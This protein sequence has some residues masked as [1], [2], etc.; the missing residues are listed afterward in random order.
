ME[1]NGDWSGQ[2]LAEFLAAV[3]S[4]P[5]EAAAIAGGVERMAEAVEA[6]IGALVRSGRVVSSVGFPRGRVPEG[7][8]CRLTTGELHALDVPGV[9]SCR[10]VSI[11]LEEERSSFLVLARSGDDFSHQE[12]SLIGA[13]ARVLSLTLRMLR[14]LEAE[15]ASRE[16]SER[17]AEENAG[18]LASLQER[19]NLL[20]RLF[21]IQQSISHRAPIADVLDAITDGA[22]QLLG[23]DVVGLRLLDPEDP[24]MLVMVSSRGMEDELA[25]SLDRSAIDEGVGGLVVKE[26][27]LVV[28]HDYA[29]LGHPL[30]PLVTDGLKTAMG[31]PVFQDGNPIGSLVVASHDADRRY[32]STEQE[33]L[34]AFAEHASLALN[35]ASAVEAMRKAFADAV[36]QAHHDTLTG[37]PNRAL[38]LERLGQALARRHRPPR[39]V[40]V[41]F[42]D[43][44]RFKVVNDTLGHSVGDEVLIRIGERLQAA[45]RPDDTVGRLAGDEFVVVCDQVDGEELLQIAE[46]AARTIEAPLSLYGRDAVITASIGVAHVS[47]NAHP[48]EVL[49]DADVAMY[50]AKQRGRARIEA[51]DSA[52]RERL[53][54]RLEIEHALRRAL[55][56]DEL[57]LH[58]QPIIRCGDGRLLGVEALVRWQH[59]DRGLVQ[60][61]GFISVAEETDLILPIGRWV[62]AEA[63]AQLGRWQA[64]NPDLHD[65]QVAVNLS[66]RQFTDPGIVSNVAEALERAG[67]SPSSLALEITESVLMEEVEATAETLRALKQLGVS[68]SIDDFGTGYS[69][70]SYL[71]RFPVDSLKI[72]R[73]FVDG[74]AVDAED[75]AIVHAVVSLA[76]ALGLEVVGEGVET[77]EQFDE[78][79][80]LGCDAAQGYLLGRPCAAGRD[81]PDGWSAPVRAGK[82]LA[83]HARTA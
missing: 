11:E 26:G 35:D 77:A 78:L 64:A 15:R 75:H 53:L 51:F 57:I 14:T 41:L 17:Q 65:L 23:D 5:D 43:L 19:Q 48:E 55:K 45:V 22:A 79:R 2:Q 12:A 18:L 33:M 42:V 50:R 54:E 52:V 69:S 36:H 29:G 8:L 39:Q 80:R 1:P 21:R 24:L 74:L 9:G 62:L 73:T 6:E 82:V 25:R 68:L 83:Q 49:R 16:E 61:D 70:L 76:H 28:T 13:M 67:I 66:A 58:Y 37:L 3:S 38:V 10:A 32:D 7:D 60:P 72:D 27:R 59:P 4:F 31:A 71:K 81:G 30:E 34:L 47:G 20:E 63:C 40:G 56:Q 46:R 44:D